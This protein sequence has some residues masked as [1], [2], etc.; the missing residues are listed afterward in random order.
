M[1]DAQENENK[2]AAPEPAKLTSAKPFGDLSDWVLLIGIL[3]SLPLLW[4]SMV[5]LWYRTDCRFFPV[6]II[7]SLALVVTKAKLAPCE[8]PR[9]AYWAMG[10]MGL[11]AV[12]GLLA[13]LN[14]SGWLACCSLIALSLGWMWLRLGGT[15]IYQTIG[16]M[17]PALVLL[18]LPISDATD[19]TKSLETSVAGAAS[20]GLDMLGVAHL[21]ENSYIETESGR[22][23]SAKALRG[24]GSPYL[25]LS[26]VVL[27]CVFRKVT[28]SVGL[29]TVLSVPLWVWFGGV[30]HILVGVYLWEEQDR[31]LFAGGR[32]T[33]VQIG[34]FAIL[35]G[36]VWLF[37][38]SL[39]TLLTPFPKY[40]TN[41][42][43]VHKIFNWL[44]T[45]PAPD[46]AK[47][48]RVIDEEEAQAPDMAFLLS[49]PTLGLFAV[50]G[51]LLLGSGI[52]AGVQAFGGEAA[53]M[54]PLVVNAETVDGNLNAETLPADLGGMTQVGFET[55]LNED[56]YFQNRHIATWLYLKG[57]KR[58]RVTVGMMGRGFY[59]VE[60][61]YDSPIRTLAGARMRATADIPGIGKTLI[62]EFELLDDI[63]GRSY[64]AYATMQ[65]SGKT[66]FRTAATESQA[67]MQELGNMLSIQPSI[68]R[69]QLF[70]ESTGVLIDEE[71]EQYRALLAQVCEALAGPLRAAAGIETSAN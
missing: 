19:L 61:E 38:L 45:W 20:A 5:D 13:A 63:Y 68:V 26:V 53:R 67:S 2:P 17:L 34:V 69:V 36:L 31:N 57:P 62:D 49:K 50:V 22:I 71:R 41:T 52:Y 40:S 39:K 14:F 21:T 66:A 42:N 60:L 33:L 15:P 28:P 18:V 12:F 56:Q 23:S 10:A 35:L 58:I 25:F 6:L 44:A 24:F 37:Q 1:S 4:L 3:G 32:N 65:L 47:R 48:R 7:T 8:T 9:R 59:P 16:W 30:L 11:A 70:G 54:T 64:V 27:L 55:F 43:D 51:L 29:L 46:P